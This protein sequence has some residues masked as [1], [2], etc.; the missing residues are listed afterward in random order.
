MC[1]SELC[2]S[3]KC[4][5]VGP[6]VSLSRMDSHSYRS[7]HAIV[8]VRGSL[9]ERMNAQQAR[10]VMNS[11]RLQECTQSKQARTHTRSVLLGWSET[12]AQADRFYIKRER[13]ERKKERWKIK[14]IDNRTMGSVGIVTQGRGDEASARGI[15]HW[16]HKL[17]SAWEVMHD[18][19]REEKAPDN[20]S[21]LGFLGEW[22]MWE[23]QKGSP[24]QAST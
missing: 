12:K 10:E 4:W 20:R 6:S 21:I 19:R 14:T 5:H 9:A 15:E 18:G 2:V 23:E 13:D 8:P 17:R 16:C 22:E 1:L 7:S 24:P 11:R 3:L